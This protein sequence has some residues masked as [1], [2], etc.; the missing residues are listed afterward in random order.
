MSNNIISFPES[1]RNT[2]SLYPNLK[3]LLLADNKISALAREIC[4]PKLKGIDL[5]SNRILSLNS[6][7]FG[8]HHFPS[9]EQVRLEATHVPISRVERRAFSHPALCRISLMFNS[10]DFAKNVDP[11]AF[12]NCSHLRTLQLTQNRFQAI[13][14]D[15]FYELFGSLTSLENL[16]MGN[17]M[18]ETIS[19]RTFAK[20]TRLVNLHLYYNQIFD[21]PEGVFDAM[22]NL[23]TLDIAL[24]GIQVIT[25][26]TF[27]EATRRRL[28]HIDLSGNP[29]HCSCD[30]IW[31]QQW[32]VSSP[33]LFN[34]SWKSYECSNAP[35]TN[36]SSF[37]LS[38]QA[39]LP[40]HDAYTFTMV[41]VGILLFALTIC[42]AL[43]RYRWHI[44]LVLYEAFR[45]GANRR[46]RLQR[47]H[48][49]YDLFVSYSAE[50][51]PWVQGHLM[52]ELEARRGLRLCIHQRDF[53]PGENIVDN[54]SD[55]V[56][57]SK[58]I[59][60]VFSRNF[61]H[62]HWCQFELALCLHHVLEQDDQLV[63]VRLSDLDSRDLTSTMLAVLKTTTYIDWEDNPEARA[64]FWGRL[65]TSLSEIIPDYL[66]P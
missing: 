52:P 32:L 8:A 36:L 3:F 1:C 9:L 49:R 16:Y 5:G 34:R 61:V 21:V 2:T 31:F 55:C 46:L 24:N 65:L 60:V 33:A 56:E 44:R 58:R 27:N 43:F 7:M 50:D 48:F 47:I 54:I 6:N 66:L 38:D 25:E 37:Y 26:K 28:E 59:L 14:E 29:F 4:L 19:V 41:C 11:T 18:I 51:L 12:A 13:A 15:T 35:N 57:A 45:G 42:S 17:C 23:R 62:S 30:I 22:I 20:L 40:S 53:I 64:S 39:C 63:V 10:I